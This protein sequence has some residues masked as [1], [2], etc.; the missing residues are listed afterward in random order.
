MTI[1]L[2]ACVAGVLARFAA[3]DVEQQRWF[4]DSLN[5]YMYASAPQR[6]Q[7]RSTWENHR[8]D[9]LGGRSAVPR[10]A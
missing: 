10:Q 6:R 4:L 3:L 1:E 7:L 9:E 5:G 2:D 8:H